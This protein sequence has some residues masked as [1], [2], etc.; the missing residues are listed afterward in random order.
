MPSGL[1]LIAQLLSSSVPAVLDGNRLRAQNVSPYVFPGTKQI[2][3]LLLTADAQSA[4]K[5]A[6]NVLLCL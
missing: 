6:C 3:K 5:N 1:V 4:I 2:S